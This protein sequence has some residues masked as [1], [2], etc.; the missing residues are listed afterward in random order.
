MPLIAL[1]FAALAFVAPA[2]AEEPRFTQGILWQVERDGRPASHVFG[3]IHL[4]DP[5]LRD[6]PEQVRQPFVAARAAVFELPD[7]PQGPALMTQAMML[8]DGRQL[9][10]ILGPEL[11]ATVAQAATRYNLPPQALRPLKP[12]ALSLFLVAPPAEMARKARGEKSLDEWLRSEAQRRGKPVH[13]LESYREQIAVFNEMTEAEQVAMVRD[14]V[15]DSAK[16]ENE[17]AALF[18]AYMKSDIGAILDQVNDM[19]G[20][21]D[22]EAAERFR[23]RLIYDR[24]VTMVTRMQPYLA[25]GQAFIA[26]GAA[27][28]PGE[29]G[30]L[31]L[32]EKQ[33]YRVTRVY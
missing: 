1:A 9:D 7:D 10:E 32:L 17:F 19:S 21:S 12:W 18:Q 8:S 14:L 29:G 16:A 5:R 15:A 30:V 20:V 24:N 6:L 25:D 26:I 33:G 11:F 13:G 27:H 31:D 23:Q 22:K 28:L 2:A 4:S 3:T